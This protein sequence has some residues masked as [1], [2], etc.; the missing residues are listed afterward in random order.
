MMKSPATVFLILA[1]WVSAAGLA[2]G[3]DCTCVAGPVL[4]GEDAGDRFGEAMSSSGDMDGDGIQDYLIG[5]PGRSVAGRPGVGAVYGLS[6]VDCDQLFVLEG[7]TTGSSF[8]YSVAVVADF[9]EDAL[10]DV[11]VGAPFDT[12]SGGY[13]ETG[14]VYLFS[15]ATGEMLWRLDGSS[16]SGHLGWAVA[17]A[18]DVN[19]DE[20]DDWIVS[21]PHKN[22]QGRVYVYSGFDGELLLELWQSP[23]S[24][25]FENGFGSC[26]APIEDFDGDGHDDILVGHPEAGNFFGLRGG[27]VYVFSGQPS[28]GVLFMK[29]GRTDWNWNAEEIGHS[30][31]AAGDRN[32]DGV[33]DI[34]TGCGFFSYSRSA[35]VISGMDGS[36]LAWVD[37]SG[38]R[39]GIRSVRSVCTI[40]DINGDGV[41]EMVVPGGNVQMLSRSNRYKPQ[42][43]IW[44]R[45]AKGFRSVAPAGDRD[46]DGYPELLIGDPEGVLPS[47]GATGLVEIWRPKL[48]YLAMVESGFSVS[49]SG[50]R[51]A[52]FELTFPT[53]EAGSVFALLGSETGSRPTIVTSGACVP[54][55][56]DA[57]TDKTRRLYPGPRPFRLSGLL[58]EEGRGTAWCAFPYET[59]LSLVGRRFWFSAV[60][61]TPEGLVNL[62]SNAVP[63]D[64]LP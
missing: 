37:A 13:L 48:G 21:A 41:R 35:K 28:G 39:M 56:F 29:T 45:S 2:F 46:G 4:Y 25:F 5:A 62:A 1:I 9:D 24:P 3:Q 52:V 60:T 20:V 61:L 53:T 50:P 47:K 33:P 43:P 8:G 55:V 54:L 14:S 26:V 11:L 36:N 19:Q 18:G 49:A 34:L 27:R 59:L 17:R 22:D 15:S 31:A 64:V 32:D 40:A 58:G 30:V 6:G 42:V 38:D 51:V 10:D 12:A 57:L 16:P 63:L 44:T 23:P 7:H